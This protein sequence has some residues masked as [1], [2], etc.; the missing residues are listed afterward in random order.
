MPLG[1][2]CRNV[3]FFFAYPIRFLSTLKFLKSLILFRLL[4]LSLRD[5]TLS[6]NTTSELMTAFFASL[7][8]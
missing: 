2:Q 8:T 5:I 1:K 3:Q 4:T 6:E 7:K